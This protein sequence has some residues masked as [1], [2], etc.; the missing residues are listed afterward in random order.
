MLPPPA[1]PSSVNPGC[2]LAAERNDT[3]PA[4]TYD[5]LVPPKAKAFRR[6][7]PASIITAGRAAGPAAAGLTSGYQATGLLE[8]VHRPGAEP[9]SNGCK[10]S[11]TDVVRG[12]RGGVG[13]DGKKRRGRGQRNQQQPVGSD[14]S[15]H[16]AGSGGTA[17]TGGRKGFSK[18]GAKLLDQEENAFG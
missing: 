6:K 8:C 18:R 9:G 4:P 17:R 16:M 13:A 3:T 1:V 10:E 14:K 15:G 5:Q 11:E 7:T 12:R 2:L